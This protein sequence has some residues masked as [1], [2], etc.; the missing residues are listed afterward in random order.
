MSENS[1]REQLRGQLKNRAML[2]YLFFD[3]IRK[4]VGEEKATAIMKRAIY[5]R[6]EEVGKRFATH[7]PSDMDGLRDAFLQSIPGDEEFFAPEVERCE[8]AGLDIKMHRCP[9][10]E[11]WQEAGIPE[12]DIAKIAAIAGFIDNGTF[13]GAGFEIHSETW[14]PGQ[15]GCCHLHIRPGKP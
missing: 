5:R 6:G 7:C 9:L 8:G 15:E 1:L 11:A 12:D 3:E 13:E 10:L 2:Y 4:E 14:E